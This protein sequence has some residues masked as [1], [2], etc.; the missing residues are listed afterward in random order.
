MTGTLYSIG[1]DEQS[2]DPFVVRYT[3]DYT[4]FY[5]A[6]TLPWFFLFTILAALYLDDEFRR[7][8]F[9]RYSSR[10]KAFSWFEFA[11]LLALVFAPLIDLGLIWLR[12][13]RGAIA[14]LIS[15]EGVTGAVFHISRL[16]PWSQIADVSVDGKFLVVQR[17]P[18]TLL[19][20]LFA[21]RGLGNINLAAHHLDRS[22]NEILATIRRMA[23]PANSGITALREA[24]E[25]T[26]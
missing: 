20:K 12:A 19:H 22:V 23:S 9:S 18:R 1:S 11:F 24:E 8:I 26:E 16:L 14:L 5:F 3:D 17:K 13:R 7:W 2:H 6:R 10:P 4:G 25:K 21:S 15:P